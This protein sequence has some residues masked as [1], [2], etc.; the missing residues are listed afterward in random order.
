MTIESWAVAPMIA[1]GVTLAT[2]AVSVA[3]TGAPPGRFVLALL[4]LAISAELIWL[5]GFH[6]SLGAQTMGVLSRLA[7]VGSISLVP[8]LT[9]FAVRFGQHL[10]PHARGRIGPVLAAGGAALIL[11]IW[12]GGRPGIEVLTVQGTDVLLG[13]AP[14]AARATAV[15]LLLAACFGVLRMRAVLEAARVAGVESLARAVFAPLL[16]F[17][18]L[19]LMMSQILLYGAFSLR[20]LAFGSLALVPVMLAMWPTLLRRSRPAPVLPASSRLT[21][22]TLVLL[23]LGLFMVGLAALGQVVHQFFP[24]QGLFWF[25]WGSTSLA[26]GFAA[27]SVMPVVRRPFVRHFD[28]SLY[29]NRWDFRLEWGRANR[30]FEGARTPEELAARTRT[31]LKDVFGTTEVGLWLREP[32]SD[33]FT[34]ADPKSRL[35]VIESDNPIH[36][37][38]QEESGVLEFHPRP[39]RLE[40]LPTLVHNLELIDTEGFRIFAHLRCAGCDLGLLALSPVSG[41]HFDAEHRALLSNLTGQLCSLLWL[42]RGENAKEPPSGPE[43]LREHRAGGVPRSRLEHGDF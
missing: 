41:F 35:P 27:L 3:R 21:A 31:F 7:W 37:A 11:Y 38:I 30:V 26:L 4:A 6:S 24:Q 18:L 29:A 43:P 2:A 12:G 14:G 34:P 32:D 5:V 1:G 13:L 36:R 28:R 25:R 17:L 22:S 10:S 15:A 23:M 39:R 33:R 19:V 42:M 40:E 9:L 8:L 20:I 16:G